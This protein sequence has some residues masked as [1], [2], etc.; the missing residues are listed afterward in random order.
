MDTNDYG[1][2]YDP[3]KAS[4]GAYSSPAPW[5]NNTGLIERNYT[6]TPWSSQGSGYSPTTEGAGSGN[7]IKDMF[8][9]GVDTGR[10]IMN[11]ISDY[12]GINRGN[13][14]TVA[15]GLAGLYQ[16]YQQRKQARDLQTMMGMRRQA[17]QDQLR[18]NLMARDAAAGKRS[19]YGGRETQLMSSLAELDARNAPAMMQLSNMQLGGGLGMLQSGI[20]S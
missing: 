8:R 16:G 3:I 12:T 20:V 6:P 2:G 19:D 15:E 1:G 10:D 7:P 17:Y 9:Q 11:G 4:S 14:G 18:K 5:A 13:F